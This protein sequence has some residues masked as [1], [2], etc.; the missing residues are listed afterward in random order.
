M[1]LLVVNPSA[2]VIDLEWET[3]LPDNVVWKG[4]E[5]TPATDT[6]LPA[7]VPSRSWLCGVTQP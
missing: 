5:G 4:S 6:G 3:A 1:E 2:E 7:S